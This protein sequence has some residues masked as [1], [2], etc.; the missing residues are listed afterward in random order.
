MK[1]YKMT[2]DEN[3]MYL[4]GIFVDDQTCPEQRN[5]KAR[6]TAFLMCDS[7]INPEEVIREDFDFDFKHIANSSDEAIHMIAGYMKGLKIAGGFHG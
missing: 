6:K 4:R 2:V 5:H 3:F 7:G 1:G